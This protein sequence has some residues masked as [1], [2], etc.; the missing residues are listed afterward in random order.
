M[1]HYDGSWRSTRDAF[2]IER[3]YAI[4]HYRAPWLLRV[5][6][7]LVRMC[8]AGAVLALFALLGALLGW[9]G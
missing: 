2:P 5:W 3:A 7:A 4:E 6:P 8:A 9:R 1:R